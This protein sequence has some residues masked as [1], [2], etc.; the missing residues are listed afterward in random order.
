MELR[1]YQQEAHDAVIGGWAE[2]DKL[3]L[4]MAT[5]TGKTIVFANIVKTMV[6]RGH[7]PLILAHRDEL[8]RQAQEQLK[9]AVDIDTAVEKGSESAYGSFFPVTVGSVQSMMRPRRLQRF[10]RNYFDVIIVDEAHHALANSYQNILKYFS[11][12]K[13]LGVTATPDRG[14]LRNLGE[15]FEDIAFEYSLTDA[16]REGYLSPIKAQTIPLSISLS[17]VRTTAGDYND[18]DLGGVIEPFL[19]EIAENMSDIVKGRKSVVF[20]PLIATSQRMTELLRGYGFDARHIDGKSTNRREI[21]EWFRDAGHGAVLC[22][23]MLLSEG[24][25]SPSV[26]CIVCLR[27]TKVRSLYAQQVGRGTRI[28]PGKENLLLLDFLWNSEKHTLCHP[29]CLIAGTEEIDDRMTAIQELAGS[30]GKAVDIDELF[31]DAKSSV[32]EERERSLARKL[33][34]NRKRKAALINPIEWAISTH[35]EALEFYEPEF[36]WQESEPTKRQLAL[37]ETRGFDTGSVENRGHASMLIDAIQKR[38]IRRLAT[39]KQVEIL[40]RF[41]VNNASE[42]TFENARKLID[43]IAANGWRIQ[44]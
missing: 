4:S 9:V 32:R 12:A 15:Y 36:K 1:P 27:P 19:D 25:D 22:N 8:I 30:T 35:N 44:A 24:W 31:D 20:L 18:K 2:L 42:V 40:E 16:V 13:V 43:E 3:L 39:E 23:S 5:G 17:N 37:L 14:D 29:A 21:L 7:R 10:P 34:S 41:C 6:D 11:G 28:N 33:E 38:R 26:D